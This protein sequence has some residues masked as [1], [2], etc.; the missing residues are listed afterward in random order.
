MIIVKS[1]REIELM[2]KAGEVVAKVFEQLE[3]LCV[4]GVSTYD[5]NEKA[6][7]IIFSNGCLAPCKGYYDYPAGICV[8]VNDTL[9]HGIPS[10]RIIL[11]EGDIVSL[12]VVASYHGY[13]A[14]ATRTFIVGVTTDRVK[15]LV[16]VTRQS[17]F[18]GIKLIRPGIHLGDVQ[19]AIQKTVES[20]GY[21][22]ARDF[23]GHGIGAH[24]HEDPSI[25][26]YG[27][28]GSGP[29]LAKG[30]ALAIEPMVTEGNP[31]TR[32]L[33]DGWTVKTRDG[34]LSCHYEN[35]V[36]VTEDGYEI[37][38]LTEKEK[39]ILCPNKI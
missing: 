2:K 5:L 27:K 8:S 38:T 10:K 30:M 24:M 12:D 23:T 19:E 33:G 4:P 31:K 6:E 29:V 25:P 14:D 16:E 3:P 18:N 28:A 37:I 22:I 21:G 11:H 39:E 35:T 9:I 17:F 1:S 36:V 15:R 13:C 7:E 26:N 34:K 32:I 20:N